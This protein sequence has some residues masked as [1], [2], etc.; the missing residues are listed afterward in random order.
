MHKS[1]AKSKKMQKCESFNQIPQLSFQKQKN[2]KDNCYKDVKWR[3][4]NRQ[5]N[6]NAQEHLYKGWSFLPVDIGSW[7]STSTSTN[8]EVEGQL[9]N[10]ISTVMQNFLM[11]LKVLL[12]GPI[13]SP[14]LIN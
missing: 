1:W 14:S 11:L 4:V 13:L 9:Q 12:E 3:V 5:E 2:I 7:Q 10:G 8:T 6:N